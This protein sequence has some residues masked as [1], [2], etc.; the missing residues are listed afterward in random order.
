MGI[1]AFSW[2]YSCRGVNVT[3]YLHW[4]TRIRMNGAISLLPLPSRS[5][6]GQLCLFCWYCNS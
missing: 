3:S 6:Q 2:E 4:I 5:W 1:L